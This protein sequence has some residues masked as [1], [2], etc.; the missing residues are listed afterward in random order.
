VSPKAAPAPERDLEKLLRKGDRAALA[1]AITL[2]ESKKPAHREQA[3][4]LLKALL[5]ATG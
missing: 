5:P 1:R 4:T 3:Q 2:V